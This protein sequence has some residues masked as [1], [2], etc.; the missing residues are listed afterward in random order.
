MG[1]Y[2]NNEFVSDG[3]SAMTLTTYYM[4]KAP[5]FSITAVEGTTIKDILFK[6]AKR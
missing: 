3:D 5:V 6:A 1:D 2:I 4:E